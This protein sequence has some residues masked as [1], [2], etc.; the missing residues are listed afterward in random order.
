MSVL[1]FTYFDATDSSK[2][3]QVFAGKLADRSDTQGLPIAYTVRVDGRHIGVYASPAHGG[4]LVI[5]GALEGIT[6]SHA[7]L[8]GFSGSASVKKEGHFKG[9]WSFVDFSGNH[10][11]WDVKFTG[12]GWR[13]LDAANQELARFERKSWK[14]DIEGHLFILQHLSEDLLAL[15]VLTS[16][17]V[18]NRVKGSEQGS[19]NVHPAGS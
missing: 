6:K 11:H 3:A 16:K 12:S 14:N 13:L 5:S 17:L 4:N 15:V 9:A 19:L 7:T 1:V 8:T 18:H 2:S 10:Y